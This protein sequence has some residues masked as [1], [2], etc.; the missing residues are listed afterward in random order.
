M[1]IPHLV[2]ASHNVRSLGQGMQGVRKRV[3]LR[4]P[5]IDCG[6]VEEAR[7]QFLT[8]RINGMVF[9]VINIYAPNCTGQRAAFWNRM[10]EARLPA[11]EWIVAGDFKMTEL[12]EDMSQG[13][14]LRNMGSRELTAWTRFVLS[15]G[16]TMCSILYSIGDWERNNLPIS[17]NGQSQCGLE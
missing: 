4:Y 6:M 3:D 11:T 13:S 10:A 17:G 9:G 5:I 8:F 12:G 1:M 15:L 14:N 16:I 7:A 2:V